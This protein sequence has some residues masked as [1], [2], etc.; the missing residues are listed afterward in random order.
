MSESCC[1]PKS[2]RKNIKNNN[3]SSYLFSENHNETKFEDLKGG[4]FFMGSEENYVFPGDGEGPVRKIYVDEFSI[5]KYSITIKEFKRFIDDTNYTTDAEKFGWSFVFYEQLKDSHEAESVQNAPWW[6]KVDKA[7]WN[8]PDGENVGIEKYPNHPVTH[9]SWRDAQEYCK[10]SNT[11][12]PTEA[13]WEFAARGGLNQ[14]KYPWGDELFLDGQIQ[15]NI[16]E[17]EFPHKNNAPESM[18]F[19][20]SV[21]EFNPNDFGLY[22]MVGNVWEWTEDWFTRFHNLDINVNPKGPEKGNN[23]VIR[24]GSFLCHDSYCNRYRTSS[25]TSNSIDSSTSNM[26]FRIVKN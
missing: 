14:K 4:W 11:R 10:W 8:L 24:G 3:A 5:S 18:R 22:N 6:I 17:G 13:E 26:G 1:S 19:T 25:R 20:T 9:I 7:Y 21:D 23:K 12:L 2:N 16:F 15:C